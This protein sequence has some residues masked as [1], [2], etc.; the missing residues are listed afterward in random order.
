MSEGLKITYEEN[1][2]IAE[3]TVFSGKTV[4]ITGTLENLSRNEVKEIVEKLGGKV[5]GSVS[6]NTD[7]VIVGENPGSKA[8]KAEELG[9]RIIGN[10]ELISAIESLYILSILLI[11]L[12]SSCKE[13]S[14]T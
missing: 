13:H 5:T 8:D 7:I 12:L 9:I 11:L 2:V 14:I 1:E 4:V 3:D 6:K 10:E